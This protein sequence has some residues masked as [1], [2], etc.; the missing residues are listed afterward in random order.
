M[1]D[2]RR[3]YRLVGPDVVW[4]PAGTFLEHTIWVGSY[5]PNLWGLY[6]M[7]GKVCEWCQ[8]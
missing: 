8:D 5:A 1:I 7:H 4:I 3:D 2:P 6:D